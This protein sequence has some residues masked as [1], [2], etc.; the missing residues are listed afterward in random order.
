MPRGELQGTVVAGSST[1]N[2]D[3]ELNDVTSV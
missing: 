3:K 2:T 1:T